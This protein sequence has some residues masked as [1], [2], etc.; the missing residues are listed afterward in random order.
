LG[1][2]PCNVIEEYW[3]T[4]TDCNIVAAICFSK[5]DLDKVRTQLI[6]NGSKFQRMRS[7]IVNLLGRSYFKELSTERFAEQVKEKALNI[8]NDINLDTDEKLS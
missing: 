2:D 5:F 3:L 7:S 6:K 8:K 1:L 4:E